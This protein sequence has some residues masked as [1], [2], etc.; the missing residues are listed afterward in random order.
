M[1][2][3]VI[4]L[5]QDPVTAQSTVSTS[6]VSGETRN[7]SQHKLISVVLKYDLNTCRKVCIVGCGV[8]TANKH[9]GSLSV[10]TAIGEILATPELGVERRHV[11]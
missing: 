9:L 2:S 6:A 10:Y 5:P 4:C 8:Y 1:T 7:L 11:L 3:T